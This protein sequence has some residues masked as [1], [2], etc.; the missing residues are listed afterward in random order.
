[1]AK[2]GSSSIAVI[3]PRT[4]NRLQSFGEDCVAS[5]SGTSEFLDR[6][7]RSRPN[8]GSGD[9]AL[10]QMRPALD[11]DSTPYTCSTSTQ[12]RRLTIHRFNP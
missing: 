3:G 4:V 9:A 6:S 10:S 11:F 2:Y 1:M 7:Q 5:T 8:S 12:V